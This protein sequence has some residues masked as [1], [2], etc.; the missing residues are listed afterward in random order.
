MFNINIPSCIPYA[1]LALLKL[2]SNHPF[3]SKPLVQDPRDGSPLL[4]NRF[5]LLGGLDT[6]GG[7]LCS[8]YPSYFSEDGGPPTMASSTP[9]IRYEPYS[10]G[11]RHSLLTMSMI[12][13]VTFTFTPSFDNNDTLGDIPDESIGEFLK[14]K[15]NQVVFK[16]DRGRTYPKDSRDI[17]VYYSPTNFIVNQFAALIDYAISKDDDYITQFLQADFPA[18][19]GLEVV[20]SNNPSVVWQDK[21]NIIVA[22]NSLLV[23]VRMYPLNNWRE[24]LF[25]TLEIVNTQII[26]EE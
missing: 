17:E 15:A 1:Q 7:L 8:I 11:N 25:D 14:V 16:K 4:L 2:V 24:S 3:L 6:Q 26:G 12:V 18:I 23:G 19:E 21:A 13:S 20:S 10:L 9:S 5:R 22:K